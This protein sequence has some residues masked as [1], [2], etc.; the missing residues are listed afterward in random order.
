MG[1]LKRQR[2]I[3]VIGR[4]SAV[5][6]GTWVKCPSCAQALYRAELEQHQFV[7]NHCNHHFRINAR[8]RI[9]WLV[10]D[11]TFEER[12][13]EIQSGDPLGFNVEEVG[14]SYS[15]RIREAHDKTGLDE[16]AIMGV[17]TVEGYTCVLG[18]MDFSFRGG[19][20]GSAF[21]EKFYRAARDA[22]ERRA[23]FIMICSSG[24]ARMEEGILAL[25][26]M[27]KT[28]DAIRQLNESAVP[29]ITILTDPT[30]GGV[31]ASFASLGD[32]ILAE[33]GAHIGFAGPRL[34]QGALKVTLP[35]G[36][37][38][39][40]YQFKH[41]FVDRI[42]NRTEMRDTLGRLVAYLS[43]SRHDEPVPETA[44]NH[45][46]NAGTNGADPSETP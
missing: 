38:K 23:P 6:E 13:A 1:F 7:C 22:V 30:T 34:I 18:V 27:A 12:H 32:I 20:M 19:S 9:D 2:F 44:D 33:P 45:V 46:E 24:G 43:P 31:Y 10:D 39:A 35:E 17:G 40:E 41:G 5:P 28:A 25:M 26:Q 36:F 14:Y 16:A 42:V 11:G 8:A 37:Q 3:S 21:G 4:K 15:K 29:Y